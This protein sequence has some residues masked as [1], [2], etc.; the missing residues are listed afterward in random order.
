NAI[1]Q[2]T[3]RRYLGIRPFS[4]EVD[5]TNQCN[6][7]CIMC[8]FSDE[9]VHKAKRVDIALDDFARIAEQ[10]FPLCHL[11][12]LSFGTEPLL[13]RRFVDLLEMV[14]PYDIPCVYMV[15][16][17]LLLNEP[18]IERVLGVNCLHDIT[19]S[20]DAATEPTDR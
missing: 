18:L 8:H 12:N 10:L 3:V 2:G 20:I 9:R 4:V 19:V 14:K 1:R 13:H 11:L 6:L 5:L 7:R 16:N 15:T 17:G